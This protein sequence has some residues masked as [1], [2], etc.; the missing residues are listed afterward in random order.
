MSVKKQPSPESVGTRIRALRLA[1]N[2]TQD[3][4][5]AKLDV[6]RSAIAQWETGRAGQ[7]R[8]NM[9]RIAKILNTSLGYLASGEVSSLHGDELALIRLYRSCTLEDRRLLVL[10]AR[11]LAS[12]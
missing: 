11:R 10:N 4:F 9:E 6:S 1:A 7:V 2:L 5:A 3:E 12:G 8:D